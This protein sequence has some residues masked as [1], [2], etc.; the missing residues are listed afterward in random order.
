M[1][2]L[3]EL[4][5]SKYHIK[6]DVLDVLFE[7][8]GTRNNIRKL[9]L[10]NKSNNGDISCDQINMIRNI[11]NIEKLTSLEYLDLHGNGC[12]RNSYGYFF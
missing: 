6:D 1:Y 10:R 9:V 2:N 7:K 3:T 5:L 11:R 8:L 12:Q 4:N